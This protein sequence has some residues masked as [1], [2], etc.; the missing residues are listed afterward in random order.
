MTL[1]SVQE[2]LTSVH[3][4]LG[5]HVL[6]RGAELG[7]ILPDGALRDEALLLLEVLDHAGKVAGIRQLQH[8]VQLVVLHEGG[9]VFDHVRVVKLLHQNQQQVSRGV[10]KVF[11]YTFFK[12]S[13]RIFEAFQ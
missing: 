11:L 7:E 4:A 12:S 2:T 5:V 1:A 10:V 3:D 8:D 13:C 9:Q 6:E